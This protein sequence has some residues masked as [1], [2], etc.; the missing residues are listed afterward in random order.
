MVKRVVDMWIPV[1]RMRPDDQFIVSYPRSGNR[2]LRALLADVLTLG[3]PEFSAEGT[4]LDLIADF[5]QGEPDPALLERFGLKT[6]ILKSHNLRDLR[7]HRFVYLF[8][9]A[10]DALVS[11]YHFRVKRLAE[12]GGTADS[13]TIEAF[14]EAMLPTWV[15]HLQIALARQAAAPERALF[16][17]YEG[18][19]A[20]PAEALKR[21]TR[22]FHIEADDDVIARA[23][24]HNG[25]EK[26]QRRVVAETPAGVAPI[27]R[28][29]RVGSASEELPASALADIRAVTETLYQ[30]AQACVGGA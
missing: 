25:F 18:L 13:M 7:G 26:S 22:F 19:H 9:R 3:R 21:V 12:T 29:G 27:L 16:T 2:W 4:K 23:I 6:R 11:Y 15:E 14:C 28:K 1:E 10:E 17:S 8:R 30:Q 20:N 24:E 5:H